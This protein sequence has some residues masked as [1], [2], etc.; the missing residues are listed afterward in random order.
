MAPSGAK[1]TREDDELDRME[2]VMEVN[3]ARGII[4]QYHGGP[5]HYHQ[6]IVT[7]HEKLGRIAERLG[8]PESEVS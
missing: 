2:L 8:E 6:V 1:P 4:E 3:R 7:N 5:A